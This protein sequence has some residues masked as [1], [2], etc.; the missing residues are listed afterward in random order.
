IKGIPRHTLLMSGDFP[1]GESLKTAE[2]PLV[3]RAQDTQIDFGDVWEEAVAFAI[4]VANGTPDAHLTAV[5]A[6]AESRAEKDHTETVAIRRE[7]IGISQR[8]AWREL[9]YSEDEIERM[10]ADKE[11]ESVSAVSAFDRA[12][13]RPDAL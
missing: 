11:T 7:R 10:E 8:Q 9:D 1:S 6:P 2:A 13:N 12:L 5:W 4:L 3:A